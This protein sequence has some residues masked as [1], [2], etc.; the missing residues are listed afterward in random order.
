VHPEASLL[1]QTLGL[2]PHPEGGYFAETFRSEISVDSHAGR[3]DAMT[4]IYYLL[5]GDVFSAFHRI[6]SDEIWHHYAGARMT[7]DS[8]DA[9]VHREFVIGDGNRW[10]I[11]IRAGLWFAAHVAEG[12]YAL[13]GC[14]VAPGFEFT[15][16]EIGSREQLLALFPHLSSLVVRWTRD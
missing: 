7:I 10:Q 13:I 12:D 16:F 6:S 8:I 1:I 2:R 14:D 5:T 3:R 11:A 9:G 4:S 15:D